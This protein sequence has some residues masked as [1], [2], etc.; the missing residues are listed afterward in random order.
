MATQLQ[1]GTVPFVWTI[2]PP[3]AG[4]VF[5]NVDP[6]TDDPTIEFLNSSNFTLTLQFDFSNVSL[7]PGPYGGMIGAQVELRENLPLLPSTG[8]PA[9]S[10]IDATDLTEQFS[11]PFPDVVYDH[12]S[13]PVMHDAPFLESFFDV[14]VELS[15]PSQW[16]TRI[17]EIYIVDP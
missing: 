3:A 8:R 14:F 10:V 5:W 7:D 11:S 12:T 2:P 13:P 9:I 15:V 17:T 4:C 6:N 16:H 1:V